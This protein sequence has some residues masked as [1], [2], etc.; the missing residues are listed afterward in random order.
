MRKRKILAIGLVITLIFG[1]CNYNQMETV[2]AASIEEQIQIIVDNEQ[3]WLDE[4]TDLDPWDDMHYA[5]TDLNQDGRLELIVT[6]G[7]IG[8]GAF[9][10]SDFYQVDKSQKKLVKCKMSEN[11]AL[12]DLYQKQCKVYYDKNKNTYNYLFYDG[13]G[14]AMSDCGREEGFFLISGNSVKI[15]NI[16]G[17]YVCY[18]KKKK[19]TVKTYYKY[20]N[21]KQKDTTKKSYK[22]AMKKAIRNK[23]CKKASFQ[24]V[25]LSK[26][27]KDYTKKFMKSYQG[28]RIS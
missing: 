11:Y 16:R 24:W 3:I 13:I 1:M 21:G 17:V 9:T 14:G 26:K 2:N 23:E 12:P 22:K 18:N 28:F 5:I 20:V 27:D 15:K 4:S 7:T 8:S 25:R 6:T 10:Y 19:K